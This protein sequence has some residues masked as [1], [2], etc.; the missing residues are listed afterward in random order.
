MQ[1]YSE[2]RSPHLNLPSHCLPILSR[3]NLTYIIL[4][5][6]R[7]QTQDHLVVHSVTRE[8]GKP[9]SGIMLSNMH[10][11]LLQYEFV[12]ISW[13]FITHCSS[14]AVVLSYQS[15]SSVSSHYSV[16]HLFFTVWESRCDLR[17]CE[18]FHLHK[19]FVGKT[20]QPYCRCEQ[21]QLNATK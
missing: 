2:N 4:T 9:L 7:Y 6:G 17:A 1:L 19:S 12:F 8:D 18:K 15:V 14:A 3:T 11:N 10:G 21:Q 16:M 5:M 20:L 13:W